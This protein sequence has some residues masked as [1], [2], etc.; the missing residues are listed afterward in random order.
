MRYLKSYRIFESLSEDELINLFKIELEDC[1]EFDLSRVNWSNIKDVILMEEDFSNNKTITYLRH[2]H[3]QS[4]TDA[5]LDIN[6]KILGRISK[7]YDLNITNIELL[8]MLN[9]VNGIIKFTVK[10]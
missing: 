4:M 3:Y 1:K 5:I 9:G 6:K 8:N 10:K 2:T 7:K